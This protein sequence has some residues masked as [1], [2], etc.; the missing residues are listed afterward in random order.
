M[1][2]RALPV[3]NDSATASRA[4]VCV[5]VSVCVCV[6]VCVGGASKEQARKARLSREEG[7]V[8]LSPAFLINQA[9]R[10]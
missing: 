7:L 6:C 4:G 9:E 5:C 3:L 10:K 8:Y 1:D 2:R